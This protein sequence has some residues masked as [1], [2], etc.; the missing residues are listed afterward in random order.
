MTGSIDNALDALVLE[1]FQLLDS[2]NLFVVGI[3]SCRAVIQ[4]LQAFLLTSIAESRLYLLKVIDAASLGNQ[5]EGRRTI[6]VSVL[7]VIRRTSSEYTCA[8]DKGGG[9]R[10]FCNFFHVLFVL[11][12]ISIKLIICVNDFTLEHSDAKVRLSE[13]NTKEKK[14]NFTKKCIIH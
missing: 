8:T 6:V 2:L 7:V 1:L 5:N 11:L 4:S 10:P 14:E 12:L 9:H 3:I 13:H